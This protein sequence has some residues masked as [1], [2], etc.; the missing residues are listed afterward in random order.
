MGECYCC[1]MPTVKLAWV[2]SRIKCLPS[3]LRAVC[4]NCQRENLGRIRPFVSRA[5]EEEQLE[6]VFA[7]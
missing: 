2:R 5:T 4:D 3:A 7:A 1:K 6:Q